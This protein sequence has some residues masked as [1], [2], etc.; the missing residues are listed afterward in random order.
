MT[1]TT[2]RLKVSIADRYVIEREP[3]PGGTDGCM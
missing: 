3:G 2:E 1:E